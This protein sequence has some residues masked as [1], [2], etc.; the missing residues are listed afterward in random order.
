MRCASIL[1]LIFSFTALNQ[2]SVGQ[3]LVPDSAAK[4]L[5][6]PAYKLPPEAIAAGID[7]KL[8]IGLTVNS[9]GRAENVKV[10]GTP[11]WPCDSGMPSS[12][13]D[14]I[15]KSV[16]E[17]V[18]E[19]R[20]SPETKEGKPRSADVRIT[21]MLTPRFIG[22][23]MIPGRL[24]LPTGDEPGLLDVGEIGRFAEKLEK[25]SNPSESKGPAVIQVLVDETGKVTHAGFRA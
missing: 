14:A 4:P 10:F 12:I 18:L 22:S 3:T 5:K 16:K 25:A 9:E 7:G 19:M 11:M 8:V 6:G 2:S 17:H 20:F 24:F 21:L 15:K 13:V 23:S 1:L